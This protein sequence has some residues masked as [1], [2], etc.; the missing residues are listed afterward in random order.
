MILN[1][2]STHTGE[3]FS[4][5]HTNFTCPVELHIR[6]RE[7]FT[8][9]SINVFQKTSIPKET[10]FIEG[11]LEEENI[12]LTIWWKKYK[13]NHHSFDIS[14]AFKLNEPIH[15][16]SSMVL[17]SKYYRPFLRDSFS[18]GEL[19]VNCIEQ[20]EKED[21]IFFTENYCIEA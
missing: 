21:I 12:F 6:T 7:N 3:N 4:F 15:M 10:T 16:Q 9:Y 14:S 1:I 20:K 5:S 13:N 2:Y 8:I 17:S 18:W 19:F 11:Y